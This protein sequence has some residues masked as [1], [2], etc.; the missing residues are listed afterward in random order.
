MSG[1]AVIRARQVVAAGGVLEGHQVVVEEGR[2]VAVE[3]STTGADVHTIA[4]G[5]VDLQVNGIGDIDVETMTDDDWPQLDQALLAQGV[6]SWQPTLVTMGRDRYAERLAH[7]DRRHAAPG[8]APSVIGVHLEGPFL[9]DR[10]GAHRWVTTGDID[11][12]WLAGLPRNV[13]MMT[14]GPERPNAAAAIELLVRRGVVV[15]LG[16]TDASHAAASAAVDAGARSFTHCFNAST[17]L[18]H[19]EP[20]AVAVAL[21][22]DRVYV[23]VIADGVHVHP[24]MIDLLRRSK[25]VDRVVFVTDAAGWRSGLGGR[26]IALREGAPRLPD[27]TLAGSVLTMDEAVRRAIADCGFDVGAAVMAASTNPARLLGLDDRGS[28]ETGRRADLVAL[29]DELRVDAT[30]VS[31]RRHDA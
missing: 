3:P 10:R 22:D 30:W 5:F 25:P 18:H 13:T 16:H 27:G 4:P 31:G 26:A 29:T 21:T 15:S 19:R 11:L 23:G 14:L 12:E 24:T 1:D 7:L 9:G 20:G 17:P 2:I 28:I 6:T 8:E